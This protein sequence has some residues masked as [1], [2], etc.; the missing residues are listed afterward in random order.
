MDNS[1]MGNN[2]SISSSVN[3]TLHTNTSMSMCNDA[4][5]P[6][7]KYK[8]KKKSN[9]FIEC[10]GTKYKIS[11]T[12]FIEHLNDCK[13]CQKKKLEIEIMQEAQIEDINQREKFVDI[14]TKKNTQNLDQTIDTI[15]VPKDLNNK[16]GL[17]FSMTSDNNNFNYGRSERN[18]EKYQIENS[19]MMDENINR[20]KK[21][22]NKRANRKKHIISEE[23]SEG[24]DESDD[25]LDE[26]FENSKPKKKKIEKE[27]E[28]SDDSDLDEYL[29]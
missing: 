19:M 24:E 4:M 18:E 3:E 29:I 17:D 25:S 26:Y 23:V 11:S 8:F 12:S 10:K 5:A 21:L 16:A 14:K 1:M 2:Y 9:T 13:S 20:N 28:K 27:E 15:H 22:N 6:K 7:K